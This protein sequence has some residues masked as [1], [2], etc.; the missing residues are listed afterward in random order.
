MDSPSCEERWQAYAREQL[1]V[2]QIS[3]P[4]AAQPSAPGREDDDRQH[5]Q[6]ERKTPD[7]SGADDPGQPDD[8]EVTDDPRQDR[9]R[10]RLGRRDRRSS[11]DGFT[12]LI[13]KTAAPRIAGTAISRLKPTAQVREN[14]RASAAAIV[15]PLRLTPGNGANIWAIPIKS[16]SSQV[17]C[18]WPLGP[19]AP[20]QP[21]GE[22]QD[23]RGDQES[24]SGHGRTFKRLLQRLLEKQGERDQRRRRHGREQSDA[25]DL[26]SVKA[27]RDILAPES[28]RQP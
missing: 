13:S 17:V 5:D 11:I 12:S 16:A 4:I 6:V 20:A 28:P 25:D 18:R 26:G 8:R 9:G 21:G 23:G 24:V 15:T 27:G 1:A 7:S 2:D 14:P 22:Q 19:V 10:D 3:R